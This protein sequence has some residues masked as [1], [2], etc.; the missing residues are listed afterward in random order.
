MIRGRE[1]NDRRNYFMINLHESMGPGRDRTR[2]PWICSQT[3][4]C[5]QTRYRLR[6]AA[7]WCKGLNWPQGYKTLCSTQLSMKFI[8]LINVK[9]PTIVGILT[10]ISSINTSYESLKER[11]IYCF[12][13]LWAVEILCSVGLSM[14]KVSWYTH[15][16][17][18][19]EVEEIIYTGPYRHA[20][21][22]VH[23]GSFPHFRGTWIYRS[24]RQ[25]VTHRE[26]D[27][28]DTFS[29]LDNICDGNSSDIPVKTSE[30][31]ILEM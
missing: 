27:R 21:R 8:L 2:D 30:Y 13:F 7:R 10:C 15:L 11:N 31:C 18:L 17:F 24:R 19:L 1:E 12:Q 22:Y 5:C 20:S 29:L 26:V 4:I 16:F 9:M 25:P 14:K 23:T 3:R 6:Y 28:E